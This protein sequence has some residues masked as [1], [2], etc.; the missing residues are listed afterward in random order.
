MQYRMHILK[1]LKQFTFTIV[2]DLINILSYKIIKGIAKPDDMIGSFKVSGV[3]MNTGM[4]TIG[5]HIIS[6]EE[7]KAVLKVY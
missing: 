3:N 2:I 7:A 6:V 1:D 5:C 4:V